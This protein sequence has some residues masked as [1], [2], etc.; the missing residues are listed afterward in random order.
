MKTRLS[1]VSNSSSCSFCIV[2]KAKSDQEFLDSLKVDAK[3]L[4]LY[5]EDRSPEEVK[6]NLL[7]SLTK[8]F[9]GVSVV[10]GESGTEGEE[11]SSIYCGALTS[12]D[13][14]VTKILTYC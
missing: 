3:E 8:V 1:F 14:S 11:D 12:C 6:R 9:E 2:T 7:C 10:F 5:C 4:A 13:E